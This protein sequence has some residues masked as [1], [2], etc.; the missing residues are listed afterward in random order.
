MARIFMRKKEGYDAFGHSST[1]L[2]ILSY[3]RK[4]RY[5][6][7]KCSLVMKNEV[8][9]LQSLREESLRDSDY[10]GVQH[11]MRYKNH[12][13]IG[14]CVTPKKDGE[15]MNHLDRTLPTSYF[16]NPYP[17]LLSRFVACGEM[18]EFNL[19]LYFKYAIRNKALLSRLKLLKGKTLGCFCHSVKISCNDERMPEK[20]W[21]PLDNDYFGF[22][23]SAE[24]L[25]WLIE[26]F[27]HP[28]GQDFWRITD[29]HWDFCYRN[30]KHPFFDNDMKAWLLNS[31]EAYYYDEQKEAFLKK[32]RSK[33]CV[34]K[35]NEEFS[36]ECLCYFCRKFIYMNGHKFR[37]NRALY[38]SN[39][40]MFPEYPGKIMRF[41]DYLERR[42]TWNPDNVYYFE[43]YYYECRLAKRLHEQI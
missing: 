3:A 20:N 8:N 7:A 27:E 41:L 2:G 43:P 6:I 12:V 17:Y 13:Y 11:W 5:G 30:E 31:A 16:Y 21:R 36:D 35:D 42:R 39:K 10:E 22:K 14:K 26:V 32:W 1:K 25:F 28:Q 24:I 23:C 38:Y 15:N 33:K 34:K 4:G 37:K 40:C 19:R 18:T 9:M 29:E